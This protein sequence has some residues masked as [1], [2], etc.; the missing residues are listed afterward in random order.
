M[1]LTLQTLL[2]VF[3]ITTMLWAQKTE[4]EPNN[5]HATATPLSAAIPNIISAEFNPAGDIDYFSLDLEKNKMYYVT[6]IENAGGMTP[7]L[8]L[9]YST[10]TVN[11]LTSSVSGRNGGGNFRLSGYIP[12]ITGTFYAKIFDASSKSGAYKI[13]LAGGRTTQQLVIHEPDNTIALGQNQPALALADTVYGAI[14]PANDIDYYKISGLKNEHYVIGTLPILDLQPRDTDTFMALLDSTGKTITENDD[15]GSVTTSSGTV[16]CTF[17]RMQGNFPH[18]GTFYVMVRSFYNSTFGETINESNP[19]TGEYGLYMVVE[20]P[21]PEVVLDRYPHIEIPTPHSV[22]VQ[23]CTIEALPTH[24]LWGETQ[25]CSNN[26]RLDSLKKSHLVKLDGL[27]PQT[28]YFYRVITGKDT[29]EVIGF[30]TAKPATASNVDFFVI[31]DSSPYSGF[32]SSPEQRQVAAQIQKVH[33]DFGLHAGDINQHRG[34][35]YDLVYYQPYKDILK[36][37]TI[38]T[39]I[40]NHD[41]AYDYAQTYLKSFELPH[42][43]PDST[44]RYYSINYGN[45]HC[46]SLDTNLP[47]NPG[48]PMYEWLLQDLKSTMRKETMWTF[49]FFHHPPWSEGWPGYPGEANVRTY[50]VPLFEKYSVDMVFNGHTHDYERGFLNGVYYIITG[51]GGCTLEDGIQAYDYPHV[52]VWINQHQFTYIQTEGKTLTL[53]SINKDGQTIDLHSFDKDTSR[54]TGVASMHESVPSSYGL[55]QNYPNP[56]NGTT[57]IAFD[58]QKEEVVSLTVFDT[59]GRL[60]KRLLYGTAGPGHH[61]LSWDGTND[62]GE[63]VAS[64]IYLFELRTPGYQQTR[65]AAYIK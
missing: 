55:Q 16:N 28:K 61:T 59:Q 19:P 25:S 56:F 6:S 35:E 52:S 33:H 44:E 13:R 20:P 9:H 10:S 30:Y 53:R 22:L 36:S 12:S 51:G 7:N 46:I 21:A 58:V 8:E 1:K 31:S 39:C 23:W 63:T 34:E 42:N 2:M 49:V 43:N 65:Q 4:T 5:S 26:L 50:L 32:A 62:L 29:T 11:L 3:C 18:S 37:A 54:P 14:Y 45:V 24:L 15:L 47:Y 17:S 60:V 27:K 38:F 40:G 57:A 48:S 41:N 64:G